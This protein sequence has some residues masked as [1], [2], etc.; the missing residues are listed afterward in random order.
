MFI[1]LIL[2]VGI[3]VQIVKRKQNIVKIKQKDHQMKDVKQ[4]KKEVFIHY[5][6]YED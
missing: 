4:K 1:G 3:D 5:H 6:Q 2:I